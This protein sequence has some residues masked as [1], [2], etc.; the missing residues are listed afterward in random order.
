M[1]RFVPSKLFRSRTMR[2][3]FSFAK[4]PALNLYFPTKAFV[5]PKMGDVIAICIIC[6]CPKTL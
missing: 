6:S 2:F 1:K 3:Q 5:T 4:L